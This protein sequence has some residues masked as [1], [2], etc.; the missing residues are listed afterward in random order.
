MT[1]LPRLDGRAL[2]VALE[3]A[4]FA[5]V[6]TKGSH[7]QLRHSDGRG[8]TVPVHAG[9]VIGSGL[10]AKICVIARLLATISGPLLTGNKAERFITC[11]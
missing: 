4:G 2:I 3:R 7:H 1:R 6:R 11:G 8:T 9:E 10:L 5:V